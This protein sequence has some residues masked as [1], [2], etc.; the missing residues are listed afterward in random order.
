MDGVARRRYTTEAAA[1]MAAVQE[2]ATQAV[3]ALPATAGRPSEWALP[4][5]LALEFVRVN[6]DLANCLNG[7][8]DALQHSLQVDDG[9]FEYD[10]IRR[11][12]RGR[13]PGPPKALTAGADLTP[14]SDRA[15]APRRERSP[16]RSARAPRRRAFVGV[17]VRVRPA[18]PDEALDPQPAHRAPRLI[19]HQG[20]RQARRQGE[21]GAVTGSP[22]EPASATPLQRAIASALSA[23]EASRRRR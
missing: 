21:R 15:A 11:A 19:G 5:Q 22:S 2:Q 14:S 7:L 23:D 3:L 10:K 8:N 1:W 16:Q 9:Y 20:G 13:E 6:S 18:D 17:V 4:L 12:R